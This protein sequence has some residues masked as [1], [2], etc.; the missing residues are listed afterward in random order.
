MEHLALHGFGAAE[1]HYNGMVGP[2]TTTFVKQ[3]EPEEVVRFLKGVCAALRDLPTGRIEAEKQVLRAEAENRSDGPVDL[4]AWRYGPAG[5]GML[6]YGELGVPQQTPQSLAG[7]AAHWFTRGNAA[8][9]LA[10]PVPDGLTLDLPEGPRRPLSPVASALP[11]LPASM[12]SALR[13]VALHTVVE[14]GP[15]TTLYREV[16]ARR[17]HQALRLDRAI[18]YSSSVDLLARYADSAEL[19]VAADGLADRLTELN[20]AFLAEIERIAAVPVGAEE[21]ERARAAVAETLEGPDAGLS[22]AVGAAT[23]TLLGAPVLTAEAVVEGLA[24]VT[25]DDVLRVA[26]QARDGAL[27]TRPPQDGV[28]HARYVE[29]PGTSTF[30]VEGRV[31]EAWQGRRFL[32]VGP[33][34]VTESQGP[35]MATVLFAQCRGLLVWPDGA[36]RLIGPDGVTVHVEPGLFRDAAELIALLDRAVPASVVVRMPARDRTPQA[37]AADP[38]LHLGVPKRKL[39]GRQWVRERLPWVAAHLARPMTPD[40]ELY[41]VLAKVRRGQVEL[42]LPLLAATRTDPET[43]LNRLG[44]LSDAVH[45]RALD[46]LRAARPDDPDVLLWAG[47]A[48]IYDAWEIRGDRGAAHV[49]A[50]K[51]TSFW[52]VLAGAAEPLLRAAALLPHDPAPWACLQMYGLGMQLDR[53]VLDSYW[54]EITRRHPA[55]WIGHYNRVQVLARKWQGSA[56]EVLAFAEEA[57]ARAVPG[58]PLT[59]MVAAAHLENAIDCDEGSTPYLAQPEVHFSLAR[60]AAKLDAAAFPHPRR[61]WAHQLFGG[62]FHRAGDLE[63]ARRHLRLAGR[64]DAD[65]LAWC[66]STYAQ[67][68]FRLARGHAG[69]RWQRPRRVRTVTGWDS[70]GCGG[71][72]ASGGFTGPG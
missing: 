40:P 50:D 53:P 59:A 48:R 49:G 21:L 54:T 13:G 56:V 32:T 64:T 42:G 24:G 63:R 72:G 34:G 52:T 45:A 23:D 17:L 10:G 29:A 65:P 2:V 67:R 16:L 71:S 4:L 69:V 22:L 6:G 7:W 46:G 19:L 27:V 61:A 30:G 36:R 57:A 62:A 47:N 14:R 5:V 35:S 26:R 9:A 1:R 60:A 43:R 55:L 37:E 41:A 25:A 8:L 38:P 51:F 66:Y 3:G 11:W 33:S 70:G 31:F 12:P 39:K 58:G 15:A 20:G 44:L 28:A 68:L 18:S